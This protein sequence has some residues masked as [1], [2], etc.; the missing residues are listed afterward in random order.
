MELLAVISLVVVVLI[1]VFA[2]EWLFSVLTS[3][4]SAK[5]LVLCGSDSEFC[6]RVEQ[7]CPTLLEQ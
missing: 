3:L 4:L 1:C 2:R 5:P 7:M 6:H